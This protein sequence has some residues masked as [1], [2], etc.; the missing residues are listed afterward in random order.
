MFK[1][2]DVLL[3]KAKS[4]LKF[5]TIIPKIIQLCTGNEVTHVALYLG[6]TKDGHIILDALTNGILLKTL[7]NEEIY[8]R[9]DD[10]ILHGIARLEGII[11]TSDIIIEASIYSRNPYGFLTI[12]NL[13]LQHGKTRLFPKKLWTTWFKSKNGHICSEVCQLVLENLLQEN[14]FIVP[15]TKKAHLTEPDDYLVLPWKVTLI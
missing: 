8:N 11:P 13:L 9:K 5:S 14:K 2:G 7:S 3:Y 4:Y 12:I 10:F 15:F 6:S 1:P